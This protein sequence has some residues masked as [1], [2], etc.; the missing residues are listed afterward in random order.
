MLRAEPS[1][2]EAL[3][4]P[5]GLGKPNTRRCRAA[6]LRS[7][8]SA[9]SSRPLPASHGQ[10]NG[11]FCGKLRHAERSRWLPRSCPRGLPVN[12]WV[13]VAVAGLLG[14]SGKGGEGQPCNESSNGGL[15]SLNPS[16]SCNAGLVCN[17]G[18]G[19][20]TCQTP[21]SQGV[22]ATC[23]SDENCQTN[24]WCDIDTC[25]EPIALG[26]SCPSGVGCAAGLVCAK[27]AVN[28]AGSCVQPTD[29]SSPPPDAMT[30]G[31]M[32]PDVSMTT[33]Q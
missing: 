23:G 28:G 20:A 5:N 6:D 31:A 19:G 17:T 33:E 26:G 11:P 9:A 3:A 24:L 13:M 7:G 25:A 2:H 14:C 32:S 21:H 30:D 27:D 12:K 29:A 16:L 4:E 1:I 18:R 15:F 10:L 8:A 22:G